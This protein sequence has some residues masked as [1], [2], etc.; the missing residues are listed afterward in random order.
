MKVSYRGRVRVL[1]EFPKD[2]D[3][4]RQTVQSRFIRCQLNAPDSDESKLLAKAM[5]EEDNQKFAE[6]INDTIVDRSQAKKDRKGKTQNV[7]D[8][9]KEKIFYEDSEGDLNVISDDEDLV[10]AS[11]YIS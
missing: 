9:S 1:K 2:M 10:N 6:I 11:R 3:E 8:F 7:I 5:E 4:F